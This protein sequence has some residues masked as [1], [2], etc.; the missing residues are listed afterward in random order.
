MLAVARVAVW[1]TGIWAMSWL[2]FNAGQLTYTG[3]RNTLRLNCSPM[4][5][6]GCPTGAVNFANLC[7]PRRAGS[8][9]HSS[10]LGWRYVWPVTYLGRSDFAVR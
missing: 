2:M 1:L 5:S 7:N 4:S 3:S 10:S 6:P 9:P 8:S